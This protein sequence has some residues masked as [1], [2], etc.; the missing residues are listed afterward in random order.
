MNR[1]ARLRTGLGH[2][3]IGLLLVLAC[4]LALTWQEPAS[5]L[6][7]PDRISAAVAALAVWGL[8]WLPPWWQRRQRLQ[9]AQLARAAMRLTTHK[10]SPWLIV[11]ASQTGM[12]EV[13]AR[14]TLAM[15]NQS[16]LAAEGIA[17]GDLDTA[18]LR[19]ARRVLFV[20]S[21]TGDADAPDSAARFMHAVM[22]HTHPLGALEYG[23]LALGSREYDAFCGFGHHLDRWLQAQGASALFDPIEVDDG[24]P[25]ALR[26]WQHQLALA[27]DIDD[28]PD[29]LPPRYRPWRLVERIHLNPGSLG[30]ACYHLALRAEDTADMHWQAGDLAEIG[31]RHAQH[32]VL[33]WLQSLS[34]DPQTLVEGDHGREP[35]A[36]LLARSRLPAVDAVRGLPAQALAKTLQ[37]LPHRE[38]SIASLPADGAL[39]L[40]VRCM[41][42]DNGK[43]GLGSGWLTCHAQPGDLLDLRIRANPGFRVPTDDCPLLLIG[44]GTGM[45]GLRALLKARIAA[46]QCDNWLL[47]GERQAG[48]DDPYPDDIA[49]WQQ[50]GGLCRVDQAHSR[51]AADPVYVQHLLARTA[52]QVR[53]KVDAGAAI[54]VC[55]SLAM[56]RAVHTTLVDT[57]GQQ[58][59]DAMTAAGRYARDVY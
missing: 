54:R 27:C 46:G 20:V 32:T 33:D 35:L 56:G 41:H 7:T 37:A 15:L 39:H 31:P 58:S 34:L 19:R 29:W 6:A 45:A 2:L 42:H 11:H 47:F 30:G 40:L 13:L 18:T 16:G 59:L 14:Q 17:L 23:L 43:P 3:G 12:A 25:D 4:T 26:R 55:G 48:V 8:L 36:E 21:T 10:D 5:M 28:L 24:N 51:D 57:L 49:Q 9:H 1:Q 22:A 38:Y 44:N 50:R 53:A 52:A